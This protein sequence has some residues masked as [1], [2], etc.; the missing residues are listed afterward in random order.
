MLSRFGSA[1]LALGATV[2]FGLA[3]ASAWWSGHPSVNGGEPFTRKTMSVTLFGAEGCNVD[4]D[5]V[6]QTCEKLH[7]AGGFSAQEYVEAGAIG[8]VALVALVLAVLAALQRPQ[9]RGVAKVAMTLAGIAGVVAIALVI[10]GPQLAEKGVK[11][12]SVPFGLGLPMFG[13][14]ALFAMIGGVLALQPDAVKKPRPVRAPQPQQDFAPAQLGTGVPPGPP[15]PQQ[16]VDVL[17]LLHDDALRPGMAP[18]SP[19]QPH[20]AQPYPSQPYASPAPQPLFQGAP[21][22]RPLYEAAPNQGGTGGFVPGP[23]APLPMRPPTP[24]PRDAISA[25]A[26]IPTPPSI[27]AQRMAEA[28]GV[29]GPHSPQHAAPQPGVEAPRPRPKTL[30]PPNRSKSVSVPP[31]L[32][33]RT[34]G[35]TAPPPLPMPAGSRMPPIPPRTNPTSVS[36]AV[37]PP[38]VPFPTG[39]LQ[40]KL[41]PRAETDAD[42]GLQTVQ[43]EKPVLDRAGPAAREF[44]ASL[45]G[46]PAVDPLA[47]TAENTDVGL[48]PIVTNEVT[49]ASQRF[50]LPT[51]ESRR[52]GEDPAA[53]PP[54]DPPA[55]T[56]PDELKT[57]AA[58][59]VDLDKEPFPESGPLTIPAKPA[60]A[61]LQLA[62]IPAPPP[63]TPALPTPAK[64]TGQVPVPPRPSAQVAAVPA[65]PTPPAPKTT[66][67]VQIPI[68]TAPESLPPPTAKQTTTSGPSPA[69]PQC[70]APMAWV[71]EHL[72]FYCKSCKMYF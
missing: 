6:V 46:K 31:P 49:G 43:H 70:E 44:D 2:F 27:E 62:A 61:I 52:F 50:E 40:G 59:K 33:P 4:R 55:P 54:A 67:Q 13:F 60:E 34:P 8:L 14:A 23:A 11:S 30:P 64:T 47:P 17:A 36:A 28:Y 12:I 72:R 68:S 18:P 22:L 38:V 39:P 10:Q 25:M 19:S 32:P 7:L 48:E 66:G 42:E 35:S 65:I 57:G 15:P 9:R 69:C 5:G 20:Y 56:D 63:R 24:V 21:Q 26:G 37:P 58:E 71:E 41:P 53:D 1:V 45:P 16:Q 3:I 51:T 29:D